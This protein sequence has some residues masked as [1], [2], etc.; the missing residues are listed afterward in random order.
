MGGVDAYYQK[1]FELL[2]NLTD[3]ELSHST[4]IGFSAGCTVAWCV[5]EKLKHIRSCIGFYGS[6]IRHYT[7]I[8]PLTSFHLCLPK[9]E[10]SF[11][12]DDIIIPL[13]K[14]QNVNIVNTPFKHGFMNR[15]SN[16]FDP[17]AYEYY[18]NWIS[19]RI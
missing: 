6:Q 12:I 2:S 5:S 14:K 3:N 9:Q 4:L 13:H 10:D 18:V 8:Q 15:Y 1:V 7:H 19:N 17:V 11:D 16:N